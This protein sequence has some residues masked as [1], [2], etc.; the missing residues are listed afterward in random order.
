MLALSLVIQFVVMR[1]T[2]DRIANFTIFAFWLRYFVSS[3]PAITFQPMIA[4]QSIMSIAS[5]F[6]VAA[7]L[8]L[9]AMT[10]L[11]RRIFLPIYF[12]LIVVC[13]SGIVQGM[14]SGMAEHITKW[15][16]IIVIVLGV[17]LSVRRMNSDVFLKLLCTTFFLPLALQIVSIIFG[18]HKGTE[19]DLGNISYIGSYHHEAEFS[20]IVLA[21]IAT[22]S[23]I[24]DMKRSTRMW[25]FVIGMASI[26]FANYRTATVAVIPL[27]LFYG[28]SG[29]FKYF[30][31][32]INGKVLLL[33]GG[34]VVLVGIVALT[35][36]SPRF[37]DLAQ[38]FAKLPVVMSNPEYM[39]LADRQ[40]LSGRF[41]IWASYLY[42]YL[43]GNWFQLLFGYGPGSSAVYFTKYAH[44]AFVGALFENGLVGLIAFSV[45]FYKLLRLSAN[46]PGAIKIRAECLAV[47]LLLLSLATMPFENVEGLLYLGLV[48]GFGLGYSHF[49]ELLGKKPIRRT[50][51][52]TPLTAIP[53]TPQA[54]S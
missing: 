50:E 46:A 43:Q 19:E 53:D 42:Q 39:N 54:D 28:T 15:F 49:G 6:V 41:V 30:P 26:V 1:I 45:V 23:L 27:V 2:K 36:L 52:E 47:G 25:A 31:K 40:L 3:V 37:S 33:L 44:N 20:V 12:Y 5:M 17:A 34:I 38:A 14:Y 32:R 24:K 16:Y 13:L 18:V 7:G 9:Y 11:S 29:M 8:T 51:P 48:T 35:A 21:F 22:I 4:G 10:Y